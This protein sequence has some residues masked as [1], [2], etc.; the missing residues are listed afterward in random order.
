[1]KNLALA[2]SV[3]SAFGAFAL[4]TVTVT[5]ID[6]SDARM[7][8]I[9][10]DLKD[11][12]AVVTAD[13]LTNG[14]SVGRANLAYLA[15]AVNRKIAA[16]TGKKIYWA[17]DK[18]WPGFRFG[19]DSGIA[20]SARLTAWA[21][22]N[23]PDW[24]AID[25]RAT[26]RQEIVFYET[27]EEVPFGIGNRLYKTD[28]LLLRRVRARGVEWI[29]GAPSDE[30]GRGATTAS[31]YEEPH[32]VTLTNDYYLAIYETTQKQLLRV[33]GER[34]S[35][36]VDADDS[37]IRPVDGVCCT[38]IRGGQS[39]DGC[40]WPD[41][42][43]NVQGDRILGKFRERTG[44][45]LDLPTSAQWEFACRAG[46][47]TGHYNGKNPTN[48]WTSDSNLEALAWYKNNSGGETHPV[49]TKEPNVW[50]FYDMYGNVS[51]YVLDSYYADDTH[52]SAAEPE[53]EPVG[54]KLAESAAGAAGTYNRQRFYRGGGKASDPYLCRSG[55]LGT[56]DCWYWDSGR[57]GGWGFRMAAPAVV[58]ATLKGE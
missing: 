1:M 8:T 25:L 4:P 37:D 12:D 30:I 46:S 58:P 56:L 43:H 27:R 54:A 18:G 5:G 28:K 19:A 38:D 16:G 15:G 20:V 11:G 45:E 2:V 21:D 44:V 36:Y 23:P 29:M 50:D 10:Y 31:K 3:L 53:I 9:T 17:A 13:I 22:D 51:E 57:A 26:N 35:A 42:G 24:M 39:T 41:K 33:Y 55:A 6:E 49:G 34:K 47:A 48:G 32:R 7:V 14:V 40:K 52:Y